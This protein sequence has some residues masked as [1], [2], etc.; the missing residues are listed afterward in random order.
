MD[1]RGFLRAF[2]GIAATAALPKIAEDVL[3]KASHL[4]DAKF[5]DYARNEEALINLIELR[6]RAASAA[7]IAAMEKDLYETGTGGE[8][9]IS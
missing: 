2:I 6:M 1:R 5:I 7:M 4:D 9:L 3:A 8:S